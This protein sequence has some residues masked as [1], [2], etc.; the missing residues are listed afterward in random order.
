MLVMTFNLRFATP[1]DGPNEWEQRKDLA[2]EIIRRQAPDLLATQE[3]TTAMLRFL[4][5]ELTEYRPLTVPRP[6]DETCQY[7]TVFYRAGRFTVHESREFWLS[8]TPEVHRSC[9]W[10]SAFPRMVTSGLLQEEGRTDPF[11]LINTHLDNVSQEARLRGARMIRDYFTPLGRP[12]ILAGDF[13]E[14]PDE[15]VYQELIGEDGPFL[16]TWRALHA[17]GEEATTQHYFNGEPRGGRIDWILVT[18]G[19]RV[20]RVAII[21]ANRDSRY[22]SDHFPYEAEVD[23]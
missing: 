9:S 1:L 18:P 22:P 19:F 6:V 10:G 14:S 11:Y 7:P 13:N 23:Y 12:L 16:D 2:V 20:R 5:A 8:Q 17:P 3:G 15:A 21:T 4:E